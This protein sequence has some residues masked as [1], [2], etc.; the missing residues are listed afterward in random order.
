MSKNPYYSEE[1]EYTREIPEKVEISKPEFFTRDKVIE[2]FLALILIILMITM[3]VAFTSGGKDKSEN[4]EASTTITNSYNTNNYNT[5]NY[6]D[7]NYP[8]S[9]HVVYREVSYSPVCKIVTQKVPLKYSSYGKHKILERQL[10]D[11]ADEYLVYVSN[12][13]RVGGY[14]TVRF[15]FEGYSGEEYSEKMTEYVHA[16]EQEIISYRNVYVGLDDDYVKWR[17]TVTPEKEVEKEYLGC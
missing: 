5:N 14:F 16:G 3:C 1:P 17:Y 2:I 15:Y 11:D 7:Y 9:S 12:E 6:A 4:H 8:S 13:D 10:G